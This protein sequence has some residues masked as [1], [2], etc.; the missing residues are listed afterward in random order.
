MDP[1]AKL[2]ALSGDANQEIPPVSQVKS[3]LEDK[4]EFQNEQKLEAL[5]RATSCIAVIGIKAV[6]TEDAFRVPLYLQEQ[7]YRIIP[8]NP[9]WEEI[10]GENAYPDLDAVTAAGIPVDLVNIFRA[11]E[12]IPEHVDEILRMP[13]APNAVWM[14]L[15]IH[16]GPSAAR[17]RAAGIPVIQD[18]CIMVD[19]RKLALGPD[20]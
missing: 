15:G 12:N 13:T 9:K 4:E 16:H 11:A 3:H 5:L 17:L 1:S 7:G 8:I 10:L 2:L 19:H 14:Q 20:K 6:E 18:R